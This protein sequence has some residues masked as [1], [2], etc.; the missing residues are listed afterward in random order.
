MIYFVEY[1]FPMS[2]THQ[3]CYEVHHY[4]DPEFT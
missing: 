3:E 4:Y 2:E 1:P